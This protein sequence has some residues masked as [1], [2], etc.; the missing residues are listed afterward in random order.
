[1]GW[2]MSGAGQQ[3][4]TTVV[5]FQGRQALAMH[6][7]VLQ[8]LPLY[9]ESRRH[10]ATVAYWISRH[11]RL[12]G[13]A[14]SSSRRR[15]SCMRHYARGKAI[16]DALRQANNSNACGEACPAATWDPTAGQPSAVQLQLCVKRWLW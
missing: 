2:F 11:R 9:T 4:G 6:S 14:T 13:A 1:M 7:S 12:T 10:A 16:V 8:L 15:A 3:A 5:Q